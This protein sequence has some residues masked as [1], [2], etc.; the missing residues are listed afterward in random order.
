MSDN[1]W[2][3]VPDRRRGPVERRAVPRGGRRNTDAGRIGDRLPLSERYDCAVIHTTRQREHSDGDPVELGDV[4]I[5]R[6]GDNIARC[7]LVTHPLGWELRLMTTVLLRS[8]V[9]RSPADILNAHEAWKA[10]ML[11]KGWR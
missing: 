1:G 4:W 5:L 6:K 8:Q 2:Q 10:A 3:L 11:D 9:C 7:I